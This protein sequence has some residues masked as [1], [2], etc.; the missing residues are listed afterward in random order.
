[1]IDLNGFE[2]TDS[3]FFLP[4][5]F[6]GGFVIIVFFLVAIVNAD[7]VAFLVAVVVIF[8]SVLSLTITDSVMK[9]NQKHESIEQ[10]YKLGYQDVEISDYTITDG[11]KFTA[12]LD[13]KYF[14]GILNSE[15][16]NKYSIYQLE[17]KE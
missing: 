11:V 5:I 14:S 6:I 12:D 7:F 17:K 8:L 10:L 1:M 2:I 15:L 3:P 4:I 9:S 13:G 16:N